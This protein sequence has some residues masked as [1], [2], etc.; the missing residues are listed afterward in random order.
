MLLNVMC[1]TLDL[2]GLCTNEINE[3]GVGPNPTNANDTFGFAH[4]KPGIIWGSPFLHCCSHPHFNCHCP[5]ILH[6]P[7][8]PW[9]APG[10]LSPRSQPEGLWRGKITACGDI[11]MKVES[12]IHQYQRLPGRKMEK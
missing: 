3:V 7:G 2:F 10:A 11:S 12:G 6:F 8:P 4:F 1:C 9:P 5:S